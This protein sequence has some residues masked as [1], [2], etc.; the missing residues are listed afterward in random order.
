MQEPVAA[1]RSNISI[2]QAAGI[3]KFWTLIIF[4]P[5]FWSAQM[6]MRDLGSAAQAWIESPVSFG[7]I[8]VKVTDRC[9]FVKHCLIMFAREKYWSKSA[10]E[11]KRVVCL[12][13]TIY[14]W[15]QLFCDW[16]LLSRLTAML[17]SSPFSGEASN[18]RE[19]LHVLANPLC[20]FAGGNPKIPYKV[21]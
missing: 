17:L 5:Q 15:P 1:I 8:G 13:R 14:N 12:T 19:R 10:K 11:T 6:L 18:F 7:S 4:L 3:I 20:G 9:Q 16:K 21:M 2:W